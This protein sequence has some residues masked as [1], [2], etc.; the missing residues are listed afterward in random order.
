MD[1]P[2]VDLDVCSLGTPRWAVQHAHGPRGNR[3]VAVEFASLDGHQ[4]FMASNE[5]RQRV[6]QR[7]RSTPMFWDVIRTGLSNAQHSVENP[8]GDDVQ[9]KTSGVYELVTHRSAVPPSQIDAYARHGPYI[10]HTTS[11]NTSSRRSTW[12]SVKPT[13]NI[14]VACTATVLHD[15]TGFLLKTTVEK[16]VAHRK[17]MNS[18]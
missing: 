15:D 12:H 8:S 7:R 14:G 17:C 9:P 13:C 18:R 6:F 3:L 4:F 1:T 11:L 16:M 5:S 2:E 10:A